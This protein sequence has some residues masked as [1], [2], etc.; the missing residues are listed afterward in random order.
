VVVSTGF[1]VNFL[2]HVRDISAYLD[3]FIEVKL[4]ILWVLIYLDP[5]LLFTQIPKC[6]KRRLAFQVTHVRG[7]EGWLFLWRRPLRLR[8]HSQPR[9]WNWL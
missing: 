8:S 5:I 3:I 6:L 7:F 2:I 1:Q 4:G 9:P